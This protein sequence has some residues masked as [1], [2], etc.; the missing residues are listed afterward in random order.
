MAAGMRIAVVGLLLALL[1]CAPAAAEDTYTVYYCQGPSGQPASTAGLTAA[2]AKAPLANACPRGGLS[3]GPPSGPPFGPLEGMGIIYRVPAGTRLVSY[4]LYRTVA[5]NNYFNWTLVESPTTSVGTRRET[6]WTIGSP[7]CSDLGDGQVSQASAVGSDGIDTPGLALWIDCNPAPCSGDGARPRVAL[8]RLL[9]VL[10][11]RS[12]PILTSPPAGD[13]LDTARP[14][15][16]LRSVSYSAADVGGGLY[17][18]ML[19]VDGKVVLTQ[20]VDDNGGRCRL[21]FLAQIP[22]KTSASGQLSFDTGSLPD[23]P[24]TIRVLVTDAT[25]TNRVA[26]A[27]VQITTSNANC[28]PAIKP[29]TTPVAARFSGRKRPFI[30]RRGGRGARVVG[31]VAGAGAGV[32]V[33]LLAREQRTG[34]R[35][36]TVG[37]SVTAPDGSF[38]LLVPP[39]PRGRCAPR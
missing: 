5:L 16:G 14:V 39:A 3:S 26:S 13:L 23:G 21:P 18:A 37:Q 36:S 27:P 4:T 29:T 24:H 38:T 34:A 30:T 2:N 35:G 25:Q 20:L 9:A 10:A 19:E 7:A 28:D 12:D 17:Q 31:R 6:C 33:L 22:C 1:C 15:S 8:H 11:D 32:P